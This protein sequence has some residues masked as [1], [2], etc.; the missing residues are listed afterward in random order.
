MCVSFEGNMIQSFVLKVKGSN[1]SK[2]IKFSKKQ[3]VFTIGRDK[4]TSYLA[5]SLWSMLI[6]SSACARVQSNNLVI[7]D[8][9]VSRSHARVEYSDTRT[10]SF[11][12]DV[13]F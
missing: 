10:R 7:E 11:A 13:F 12:L 1:R 6:V 4:V 3:S 8:S 2:D 9:R 5:L